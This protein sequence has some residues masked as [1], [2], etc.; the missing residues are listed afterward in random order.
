M[1]CDLITVIRLSSSCP[2]SAGYSILTL[3]I[4]RMNPYSPSNDDGRCI[5]SLKRNANLCVPA[6]KRVLPNFQEQYSFIEF[7]LI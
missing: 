3:T 7:E 5:G 2:G 6:S 4:Y 1:S